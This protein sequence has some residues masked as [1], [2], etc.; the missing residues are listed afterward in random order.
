MRRYRKTIR[1]PETMRGRRRDSDST[2]FDYILDL[3]GKT[4]DEAKSL[5]N[6][7]LPSYSK[8]CILIIHG[9]G[10]GILR[11]IIRAAVSSDS[12]IRKVEFGED[13][14]IQGGDGVTVVYTE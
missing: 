11:R 1:H 7:V 10:E 5:L 8:S 12:R 3:H 4:I 13:A 6:A 14:H 9:K 2:Q